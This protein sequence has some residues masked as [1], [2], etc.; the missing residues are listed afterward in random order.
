VK[1]SYEHGNEPSGYIKCWEILE[2]LNDWRL[3]NKDPAPL[4]S[5]VCYINVRYAGIGSF[6]MERLKEPSCDIIK[7]Y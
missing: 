6:L 2:E 7:V 5:L 1:G 4:N 3:L